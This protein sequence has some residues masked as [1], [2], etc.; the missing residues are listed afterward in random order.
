MRQIG[1]LPDLEQAR[2]FA[3]YLLTRGITTKLDHSDGEVA[4]WIREEDHL[5]EARDELSQFRQC[6]TD[7]R[8]L[9]ATRQARE[10]RRQQEQKEHQFRR[11][12]IDMRRRWSRIG[13]A[14]QRPLTVLLIAASVLFTLLSGW[15]RLSNPITAELCIE[16]LHVDELGNVYVEKNLRAVRQGQF[17]RLFTPVLLHASLVHLGFNMLLLYDLGGMVESRRG[18]LRF[19]LLVLAAAL[20]SNLGQYYWRGPNFLGMS[21]VDYA[22]FGYIWMKSRFDPQAG[23]YIH[24][25]TVFM[26]LLWFAICFLPVM[27][28][29]NG[30][31]AAG[32]AVGV[33]TG[34]APVAWRRLLRR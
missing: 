29:A 32:L 4:I 5:D 30:A 3:D 22:L 23:L 25:N 28:I 9:E 2:T 19:L 6:A 27:R 17:W 14:G 13:G 1:T 8:Y 21:G 31:H 11:N 16:R 18:S 10:L 24:P 12:M 15:G 20:V 33:V 26:L 34:Y 7:P